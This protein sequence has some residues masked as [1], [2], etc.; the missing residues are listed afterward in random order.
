MPRRA[1]SDRLSFGARLSDF[2]PDRRDK[3]IIGRKADR[4][5]FRDLNRAEFACVVQN[6]S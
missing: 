1:Y 6:R 3:G 2:F 5:M 4:Q